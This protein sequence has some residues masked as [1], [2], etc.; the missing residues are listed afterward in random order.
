MKNHSHF[1]QLLLPYARNAG[2]AVL[3]II[4]AVL[5]RKYLLGALEGRMIWV[6]FYPAVVIASIYGGWFA[7]VLVSGGTCIIAVHGWSF[8][9]SSPFIKDSGDWLGLVAFLVNC[10]MITTV[11]EMMRRAQKRAELDRLEAQNANKAK[12]IFLANMSHE[13]RTPLNAILGFSNLLKKSRE[14]SP[15]SRKHSEIIA[16]SG[17]NLLN[18]I[19]NI[20]DLSKMEAGRMLKDE[21]TVRIRHILHEIESLLSVRIKEKRLDFTLS[22]PA[23]LPAACDG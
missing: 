4:A 21:T 7:G 10:L 20:L 3:A 11:A 14:L 22:S 1:R 5:M 2:I 12:S 8:L 9:W 16:N 6:T 19:N 13:L 17:E 23:D 18:L 15:E